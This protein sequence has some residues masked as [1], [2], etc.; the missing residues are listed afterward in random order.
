MGPIPSKFISAVSSTVDTKNIP[1]VVF[2]ISE[3]ETAGGPYIVK[4]YYPLEEQA[5]TLASFAVSELG[6]R[7]FAV[8]YPATSF[9]RRDER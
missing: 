7:S 5:R 4:F 6:V 8:L 3:S 1:T 9:R 2:P